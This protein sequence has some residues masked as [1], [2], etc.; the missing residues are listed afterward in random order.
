MSPRCHCL[1]RDDW[2]RLQAEHDAEDT[3]VNLVRQGGQALM[4]P[5]GDVPKRA[6]QR[7]LRHQPQTNLTRDDHRMHS[8]ASENVGQLLHALQDLI[9]LFPLQQQVR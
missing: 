7:R 8:P 4:S 6:A 3:K 1:H 9:C 2:R 5:S